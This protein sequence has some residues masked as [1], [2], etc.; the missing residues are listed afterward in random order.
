MLRRTHLVKARCEPFPLGLTQ[1]STTPLSVTVAD[2]ASSPGAPGKPSHLELETVN[3]GDETGS[4][5]GEGERKEI[6]RMTNDHHPHTYPPLRTY[7]S[8]FLLEHPPIALITGEEPA[9]VRNGELIQRVVVPEVSA[10]NPSGNFQVHPLSIE[11]SAWTQGP[12]PFP[13]PPQVITPRP[14]ISFP[15]VVAADPIH[16]VPT[17]QPPAAATSVPV[18]QSTPIALPTA[19]ANQSQQASITSSSYLSVQ[20]AVPLTRNTP[21]FHIS[22]SSYAPISVD[23]NHSEAEQQMDVTDDDGDSWM[24]PSEFRESPTSMEPAL[25]SLIS[26]IVMTVHEAPLC[27]DKDESMQDLTVITAHSLLPSP[28]STW[29]LRFRSPK[30]YLRRSSYGPRPSVALPASPSN[31]L[32]GH[33]RRG[34]RPRRCYAHPYISTRNKDTARASAS[35]KRF[36]LRQKVATRSTKQEPVPP[37]TNDQLKPAGS[38]A[39]ADPLSPQKKARSY[40]YRLNTTR[41]SPLSQRGPSEVSLMACKV[42]P[43]SASVRKAFIWQRHFTARDRRTAGLDGRISVVYQKDLAT[44]QQTAVRFEE[45][46]AFSQPKAPLGHHVSPRRNRPT[47]ADFIRAED[48]EKEKEALDGLKSMGLNSDAS[49]S[50][51]SVSESETSAPAATS[52]T[53]KDPEF[54]RDQAQLLLEDFFEDFEKQTDLTASSS[55][56]SSS[57]DS[58]S[59]SDSDD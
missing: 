12:A 46:P 2:D 8:L 25:S 29:G 33:S 4:G 40:F 50:P 3:T 17:V 48:A 26:A 20:S 43:K 21:Q 55:S 36:L 6:S 24:R 15:P 41:A 39:P 34:T 28:H 57:S 22:Q 44:G 54:H 5:V 11:E 47:A 32:P 58:G 7:A 51:V 59:D 31:G 49:I 23:C 53:T 42:I 30:A 38:I 10:P 9:P 16:V 35:R 13:A 19:P 56:L 37:Q 45:Q 27:A 14:M 18:Q 52:A 1:A